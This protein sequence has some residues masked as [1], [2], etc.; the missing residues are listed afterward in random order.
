MGNEASLEGEG[1]PEGL[2]AAA[3][4]AAAA[5]GGAGGAGSSLHTVIPAGMEADL[6]QLSEEE[7]RQ[8]AA[9]MS[10][11]QGL[12]KGS[13]PPAA[14]EQPSMHRKQ[15]LDS[16][17]PPKQPGKPPDPGRSAPPGLSKSRTTDTL[18]SEQKSPGRS[19]S[20]IS[21]K[22]SKS[23]TDLKEEH[24]SSMMPGF[25]SEVNPLSAVSSVVNKFNPFDLIS[26]SD[27]S[28][29]ETAKKQKIA[30]KE[31]GK[32]EGIMKPPSQQSPKP[33]PKPQGPVRVP[34]Q[35][36][37]SPKSVSSQQPEKTKSQ[38]PG[39][40][41]PT[42]GLTQ[43]PQTDQAHQR[44]AAKPQTKQS[45]PVRGESVKPS[46]QSPSKPPL[47]Q[48]SPG[49]PPAQQPGPEKVATPHPGP[50]KPSAQQPG[51]AKTP[52][53]QPG[54][55][56]PPAKPPGT[57]KP[58][59]QQPGPKSSA[60]PLGPAK[61]QAQ[62]AGSEKLPSQQPA[63]AKPPA[64]QLGTTK[65]P[66][67][68]PGPQSPAQPPGPPKTPSQQPGPTKPSPQQPGPAKPPSQ[69]PGSAKPPTQQPSSAK[70][71][72]QQP[73]SAK[74]PT[75][76]PGSAKPPIQQPG[77]AKPPTQQPGSAKP[78]PQQ[79]AKPSAQ[80]SPKPVSQT[81]AGKPLQP[82]TSPSV[83]Q[84]PVQG[85]PKTICP[86]CSTTELLLHVPEKANFNTCTEC[87][88]TVCSLC[89]FNPNPHL[90]E[91]SAFIHCVHVLKP[92]HHFAQRMLSLSLGPG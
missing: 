24:K 41:K 92:Y 63:P 2:A 25:L 56:K 46:V 47:Q 16:S 14:A 50:A 26:D 81:G 65:S 40:G 67:D 64:Q 6:S 66:A 74:P 32:P 38:P 27:A 5:G 80:Q 28:Q 44:D 76:Q 31:Q 54:T 69:Q 58:A 29:E 57:A 7:R 37:G 85:L 53:Q 60:Q 72:T 61:P 36:D 82:S 45:D 3:A 1:L 89:G 83:E 34:A 21:L 79:P 20:T 68:Q 4:A 35:Q 42:Q 23:R 84:T 12:P 11:A 91:V 88:T 87:Q 86:L 78:S 33:G 39:T 9:V 10:R 55:G 8:I 59:A 18:R 43:V 19:P 51:P 17:H 71:P 15:E 52:A 77:S 30:Q 48:A 70:P 13:V 90:T 73:G 62:Q 49:K 22:E 75:Q